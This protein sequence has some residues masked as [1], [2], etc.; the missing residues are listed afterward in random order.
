M[1][2]WGSS[3]TELS[4]WLKSKKTVINPQNKDEECFTWPVIEALHHQEI[5]QH[6][7]R[8]SLMRPYE[9]RYN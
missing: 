9:N 6:P 5:K 1:L 3:Y 8:I 2:T 7:E 4:E